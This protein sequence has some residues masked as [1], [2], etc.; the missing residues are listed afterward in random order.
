MPERSSITSYPERLVT[1]NESEN[2]NE[3]HNATVWMILKKDA[4]YDAADQEHSQAK[5]E[6]D[7]ECTKP[8]P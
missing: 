1:Q 7:A 5:K 4:G 6:I 2:Q 3:H 8:Q